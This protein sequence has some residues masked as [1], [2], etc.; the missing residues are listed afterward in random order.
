[1]AKRRPSGFSLLE[2]VFVVAVVAT[3]GAVAV[4][5]LSAAIGEHQTAGAARYVATRLQRARMESVMRSAEVAIRFTQTPSGYSF[6]MYVDGNRNGVLSRDIDRGVDPQIALPERLG[7]NFSG[8]EFGAIPGVPAVDP[9]GTAP[10]T[11]P[12][13]LGSGNSASFAPSGTSSSGSLYIRGRKN[14]QYVVRIYGETGKTR[15]LR[16]DRRA[17]QWRPL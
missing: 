5:Q 12:I 14:E 6:A 8:T 15:V 13:R 3:A 10:G 2:L 11:D 16:F 9:G 4:P 17:N 7:D 1:V